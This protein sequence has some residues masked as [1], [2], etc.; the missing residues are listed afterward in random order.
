MTSLEIREF[1]QTISNYV[2]GKHLPDEVKKMVLA[3]VLREQEER[4]L[5]T[6]RQEIEARDIAEKEAKQD[7]E[8]VCEN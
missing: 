8:S 1:K 5:L 7:A 4:T 3:E 2:Q 6:L